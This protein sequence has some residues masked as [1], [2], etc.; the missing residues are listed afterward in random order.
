M[1]T[2]LKELEYAKKAV[3]SILD[4][5]ECSVDFHGIEYWAG[6]VEQ[7]RLEIKAEL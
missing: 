3:Q 1:E 4:N 5:G 7:K 2:K 6:V